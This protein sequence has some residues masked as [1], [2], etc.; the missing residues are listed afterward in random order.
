M[1]TKYICFL[2]CCGTKTPSGYVAEGAHGIGPAELPNTWDDL[3]A[4]R[5]KMQYCLSDES[6][7]TSALYLYTGSP[8]QT[9]FHLRDQISK[10]ILSG[11][12][13]LIIIS[14]G[15]GILKGLEPIKNYDAV[16]SHD[17]ARLWKEGNLTGIIADFLLNRSP[18]Y[19]YGFFAGTPRFN[20]SVSNYRYFFTEGLRLAKGRGLLTRKSGCFFRSSGRGVKAILGGLGR[21]FLDLIDCDFDEAFVVGVERQGKKYGQ[22]QIGFDTL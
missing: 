19:V 20:A 22:V 11:N 3:K 2:P 17:V 16:L 14:A 5:S 9:F 1:N 10:M 7:E 8:Y 13:E 12:M 4:G 15:Y 18:E 6:P 21:A